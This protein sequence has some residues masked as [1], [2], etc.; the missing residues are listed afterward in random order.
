[1]SGLAHAIGRARD[2]LRLWWLAARP[3]TLTIAISPVIL[4]TT[5]AW[6]EGGHIDPWLFALTL[7]AAVLIQAG[8]NLHNDAADEQADA[9]VRRLGPPRVSAEGLLPAEK[10]RSAAYFCFATAM[11]IGAFLVWHGGWPI[12]LIGLASIVAG[13]AYSGGPRPISH[14]PLGELFVVIFFG[15]AGVIGTYWL[16]MHAVSPRAVLGGFVVGLPAAAVLLVN[17]TRDVMQDAAAGRF[18]LAMWLGRKRATWAY[19]AMLLLP[20]ALL[21]WPEPGFITSHGRFPWLPFLTLPYAAWLV[22]QF[23]RMPLA[24]FNFLLVNTAKLQFAIAALT[25]L[26]L[27]Q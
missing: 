2:G 11:L 9:A 1:M 23:A 8:T 5:L 12:L 16:Q 22:A 26:A 27:V 21:A 6:L 3:K 10:V 20:Y 18:T 7:A 25:C 14:T 24:Q 19:A 15:L 4:G 17:N 13:I